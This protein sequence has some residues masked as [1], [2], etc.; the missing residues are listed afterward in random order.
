MR[1]MAPTQGLMCS[2]LYS[3]G[4]CRSPRFCGSIAPLVLLFVHMPHAGSAAT[5]GAAAQLELNSSRTTLPSCPDLG[6]HCAIDAG[7][8]QADHEGAADPVA[9]SE[10]VSSAASLDPLPL[11][12]QHISHRSTSTHCSVLCTAVFPGSSPMV[13][14][15]RLE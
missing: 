6:S 13:A 4:T 8:Q 5:G 7:I 10:R 9:C 14:G 3:L 11:A 2:V 12:G 15:M 1:H